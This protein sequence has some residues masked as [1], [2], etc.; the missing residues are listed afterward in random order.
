MKSTSSGQLNSR[1]RLKLAERFQVVR[2]SDQEYKL[3]SLF[4]SLRIKAGAELANLLDVILPKLQEGC[5]LSQILRSVDKPRRDQAQELIQDLFNRGLIERIQQAKAKSLS[6]E[7][8][9]EYTEQLKFFSNFVTLA[10]PG[11]S[12]AN[13]N[14]SPASLLAQKRL[15][16]AKVLL[17][18]LGRIGSRLAEGLA[19]WEWAILSALTERW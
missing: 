18:G 4:E 5:A 7:E 19:S 16:G 15:K 8:L 11:S 6:D 12:A 3:V 10:D 2:S 9:E 13:A 17:L 14:Y 1:T